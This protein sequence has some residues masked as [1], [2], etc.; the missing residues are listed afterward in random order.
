MR[1]SVFLV[2]CSLLSNCEKLGITTSKDSVTLTSIAKTKYERHITTIN[3]CL[4]AGGGREMSA[5]EQQALVQQLEQQL[6]T[7]NAAGSMVEHIDPATYGKICANFTSGT[8]ASEQVRRCRYQLE[9]YP[10]AAIAYCLQ[11]AHASTAIIKK[12]GCGSM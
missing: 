9:I 4:H 2:L 5:A 12:N 11:E 10:T 1:G 3:N 6:D 7:G 8:I